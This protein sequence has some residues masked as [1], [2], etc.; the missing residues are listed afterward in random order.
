M[1]HYMR[2]GCTEYSPEHAARGEAIFQRYERRRWW[3]LVRS[4][5]ALGQFA[6]RSV[7]RPFRLL[8]KL[9]GEG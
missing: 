7:E 5:E 1:K 9:R 3:R 2:D 6:E 4:Q 8:R